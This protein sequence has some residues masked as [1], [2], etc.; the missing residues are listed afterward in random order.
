M[1]R[2]FFWGI[3]ELKCSEIAPLI[4]GKTPGTVLPRSHPNAGTDGD[5]AE[6]IPLE[7]FDFESKP[8][9][10]DAIT[11]PASKFYI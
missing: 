8:E 3:V 5:A 6:N 11:A 10:Q 7:A 1:T 4:I 2:N 9:K